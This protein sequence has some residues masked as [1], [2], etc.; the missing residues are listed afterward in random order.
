MKFSVAPT[1][2]V[3]TS[4][5]DEVFDLPLQRDFCLFMIAFLLTVSS[6]NTKTIVITDA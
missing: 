3:S 6:D 2:K 1:V 5:I 4:R